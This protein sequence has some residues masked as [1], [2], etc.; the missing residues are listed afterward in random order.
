MRQTPEREMK[1]ARKPDSMP[2]LLKAGYWLQYAGPRLAV[3]LLLG[4]GEP[5]LRGLS[6]FAGGVAFRL[7]VKHRPRALQ[8]LQEVGYPPRRARQITR[9]MFEHFASSVVEAMVL[10]R[11]INRDNWP[12]YVRL[13]G[14]ELLDAA[15]K[16]GG[17]LL[18][19][20][21]QGSWEL[22]GIVMN[23]LGYPLTSIARPF[24]N[25]YVDAFLNGARN[26]T[27]G[28]VVRQRG[29]LRELMR[30]V[31]G[32]RLGVILSDQNAGRDGI[33]VPFFGR[34]ASTW[35]TPAMLALKTG[36]RLLPF[37]TYRERPFH[38]VFGIHPDP[39]PPRTGNYEEDART[40]TAWYTGLFERSIRERPE[41]WLWAHRRWR[42]R[43]RAAAA[44]G[45]AG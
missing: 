13:E 24:R 21:H 42:S 30:D 14:K 12:K 29:G 32:G 20:C 38:Y 16:D 33:F 18:V 9:R 37:Y 17:G 8:H 28:K 1:A 22:A 26:A 23:Q 36:A 7:D 15:V 44:E 31:K 3:S 10:R 45:A 6:K 43:P 11:R 27:G 40:I 2:P 35:P 34:P 41:Q 5:M 4:M 19:G 25:P 39:E